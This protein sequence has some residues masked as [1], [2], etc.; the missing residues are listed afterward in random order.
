MGVFPKNKGI[1][2][3]MGC[4]IGYSSKSGWVKRPFFLKMGQNFDFLPPEVGEWVNC[5]VSSCV[6]IRKSSI[7]VGSGALL[8]E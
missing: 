5:P 6:T 8:I 7:P 4:K 3:K 2:L 1:F